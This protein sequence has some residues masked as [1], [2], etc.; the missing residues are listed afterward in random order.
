MLVPDMQKQLAADVCPLAAVAA[1]TSRAQAAAAAAAAAAI[2]ALIEAPPD[3]L[4]PP[5]ISISH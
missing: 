2:K 1:A 5:S 3:P 4:I